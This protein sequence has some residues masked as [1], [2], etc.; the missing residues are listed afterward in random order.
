MASDSSPILSMTGTTDYFYIVTVWLWFIAHLAVGK[1]SE[2][3]MTVENCN[4]PVNISIKIEL[5]I[6]LA[7]Q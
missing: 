5:Q 6:F 7:A 1:A 4:E 2:K 3:K